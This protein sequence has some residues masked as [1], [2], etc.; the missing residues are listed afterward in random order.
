[1]YD[2]NN[3]FVVAVSDGFARQSARRFS[4]A[5]FPPTPEK[6]PAQRVA[7]WRAIFAIAPRHGDLVAVQGNNIVLSH[8]VNQLTVL[9][10]LH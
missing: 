3:G 10:V 8:G 4:E 9:E 6:T 7:A 2:T 1:M 5:Q